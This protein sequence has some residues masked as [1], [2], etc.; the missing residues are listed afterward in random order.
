MVDTNQRTQ[1][2]V[3]TTSDN[4]SFFDT[5]ATEFVETK[6]SEAVQELQSKET[7]DTKEETPKEETKE[8][9]ID[10]IKNK[11]FGKSEEKSAGNL[12]DRGNKVSSTAVEEKKQ[13]TVE[14]DIDEDFAEVAKALG[15]SDDDIVNF[16]SEYTN[17]QL[18]ELI[19]TLLP[20]EEEKKEEKEVTSEKKIDVNDSKIDDEKL[21][22][23]VE[24][25]EKILEAK[26]QEKIGELE[27][28]L[29]V[30]DQDR[31]VKEAKQYQTTAD[32]FFDRVAKEFPVFG[33]TKDLKKFPDG[34]VVPIGDN[35]E[36]RN[37]VWQK[38]IAFH[39]MGADWQE[40]LE[41]A[42]VWYKGKNLEKDIRSKVLK[43]LKGNEKRLS[44]KRTEF[45]PTAVSTGSRDDVIQD[46]ARKVGINV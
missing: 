23:Y 5:K 17:Q 11:V 44:P 45:S 20:D 28:R 30:F 7:V 31:S 2:E 22:P 40:S 12:L 43:E 35:F 1:Q 46:I 10:R 4:Q 34:Q 26:Y 25:I 8:S 19:P 27:E 18:K 3:Q 16:A 36:A 41:D 38:A 37:S 33:Q 42:L 13:E 9:I 29:S 39:K 15:W 14:E 21:R 32:D 6:S 24:Q